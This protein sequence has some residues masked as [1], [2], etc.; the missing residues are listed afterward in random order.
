MGTGVDK[1]EGLQRQFSLD[2]A[3]ANVG[4]A[5]LPKGDSTEYAVTKVADG[6]V[7]RFQKFKVSPRNSGKVDISPKFGN[8][9]DK[10]SIYGGLS[11]PI[12]GAENK[13]SVAG[14]VYET[15]MGNNIVPSSHIKYAD[16][17][18]FLTSLA[19]IGFSEAAEAITDEVIM[20]D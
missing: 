18:S 8:P 7:W 10:T 4:H 19:A 13:S 20:D 6:F 2:R 3:A 5:R 16:L 15:N 14:K 12:K 17:R 11:Q 1:E 9:S